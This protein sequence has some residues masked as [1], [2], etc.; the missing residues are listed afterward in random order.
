[1]SIVDVL[2]VS[3]WTHPLPWDPGTIDER[4]QQAG[5]AEFQAFER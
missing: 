5:A 1:M 2:F 3:C 4:L